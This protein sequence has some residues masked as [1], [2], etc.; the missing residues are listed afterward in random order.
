MT[1]D[2]LD[3]DGEAFRNANGKMIRDRVAT[4]RK[5]N[6]EW[7]AL[8]TSEVST[9]LSAVT[10]TSFTVTYLDPLTG[11]SQTKTFY[12]G[13]RNSPVYRLV[14]GKELWAGLTMNFIEI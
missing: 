14:N 11:T 9:L 6:C 10:A 8:T 1:V 3:I 13:D 2:V 7:S 4:K 12:V 5:L